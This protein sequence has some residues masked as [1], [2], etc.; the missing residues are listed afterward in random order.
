MANRYKRKDILEGLFAMMSDIVDE[1]YTTNR[2]DV[3][4]ST[5][6]WAAILLPYGINA[7][8]S[9]HNAAFVRIQLFYK[10]RKN[11]IENVDSGEDIA[12]QTIN[13]IKTQLV[14]GGTYGHLMTCNEEPRVLYF[15]SDHMGY[16][17]ISIQ[18]RVII[19]FINN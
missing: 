14:E 16:H 8:S 12:D 1:V 15:K 19:S 11:G 7:G 10:D 4:T 13:A 5:D 17:V 18:F 2:P 9:I 3:K 6:T